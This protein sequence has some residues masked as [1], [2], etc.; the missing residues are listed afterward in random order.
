MFATSDALIFSPD[1]SCPIHSFIH[2]VSLPMVTADATMN[3]VAYLWFGFMKIFADTICCFEWFS[4]GTGP[5][6]V[7]VLAPFQSICKGAQKNRAAA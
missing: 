6:P 3:N 5:G 1:S 2:T 4:A 7:S